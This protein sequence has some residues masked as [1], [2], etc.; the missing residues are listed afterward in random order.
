MNFLNMSFQVSFLSELTLTSGACEKV[1]FV[2]LELVVHN[3]A[4]LG[5]GLATIG[6][7]ALECVAESSCLWIEISNDRVHFILGNYFLTRIFILYLGVDL[8][9]NWIILAFFLLIEEGVFLF[10]LLHQ[11]VATT[12]RLLVKFFKSVAI[13][14]RYRS[15]L[16][17]F[18]LAT[19]SFTTLY[20]LSSNYLIIL[21]RLCKIT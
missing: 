13:L 16:R 5:E 21:W 1:L 18:S 8:D 12:I 11:T 19:T 2:M 20:R 14:Y 3:V 4:A 6:E 17:L 7:V 10:P 9:F 15:C